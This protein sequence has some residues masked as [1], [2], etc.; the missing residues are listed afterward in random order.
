M[1]NWWLPENVST[2]GEE[3]DWLF[4][5]IYWITGITAILVFACDKESAATHSRAITARAA[6]SSSRSTSSLP[7]EMSTSSAR[8]GA[9]S[10]CATI[11]A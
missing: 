1:L 11:Q 9:S 7:I 2:Y 4:H 3:I 10:H 8:T 6:A 5:L